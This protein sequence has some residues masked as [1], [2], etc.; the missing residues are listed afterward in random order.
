MVLPQ[1]SVVTQSQDPN[2]CGHRLAEAAS[3]V[4]SV[5]FACQLVSFTPRATAAARSAFPAET[6]KAKSNLLLL[7]DGNFL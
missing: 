2:L 4:I 5:I 1:T 3:L 7:V 6:D